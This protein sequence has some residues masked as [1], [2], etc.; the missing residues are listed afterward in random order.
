VHVLLLA[1]AYCAPACC[2]LL[3]SAGWRSFAETATGGCYILH[4]GLRI[5]VLRPERYYYQAPG[6]AVWL[7]EAPRGSLVEFSRLVGGGCRSA[8]ALEHARSSLHLPL[9]F[10][11][12][13]PLE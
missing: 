6:L 3:A 11:W 1:A 13:K 10:L 7:A 5:G 9:W 12:E 8:L 4:C 2:W